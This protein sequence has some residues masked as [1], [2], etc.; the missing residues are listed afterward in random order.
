M[1]TRKYVTIATWTMSQEALKTFENVVKKGGKASDFIPQMVKVVEDYPFYKSVG[2]GGLPNEAGIVQ[3]D[4]AYMDGNTLAFGAVAGIEDFANP[5]LIAQQ[6]SENRYNS[7]LIGKGAIDYAKTAGFTQKQMLSPRAKKIWENRKKAITDQNLTPYDGHDTVCI[8]GKDTSGTIIAAT[9]TS[10]L[11]MK[12]DG[13][14]GDSPISGSGLYANSKI[15]AAAATGLGED[16]M[17]TCVSYQTVAYMEDGLTAQQ[18]VDKA[19]KKA[20]S[21]LK[22]QSGKAGDISVVALDKE[23]NYGCATNME[24]F[25]YVVMG[26]NL[27][28]TV[29]LVTNTRTHSK[30]SDQWLKNYYDTR[31]KQIE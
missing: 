24:E 26:E 15:G 22:T 7:F 27:D 31:H 3:L 13:R 25:S 10:G 17:K 11:F 2:Y 20:T 19:V 29:Y 23:G 6:L 8:L 30:A 4:A 18:A 9:S 14:V 28:P 12:K 5:I 1:E 21:I 16:I